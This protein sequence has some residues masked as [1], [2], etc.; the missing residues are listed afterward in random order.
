VAHFNPAKVVYYARFLH[1]RSEYNE[2]IKNIKVRLKKLRFNVKED[3]ADFP[4]I[5]KIV[6]EHW[7][8]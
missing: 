2:I 1:G 7:E 4:Q 8:D 6:A 3:D 5:E